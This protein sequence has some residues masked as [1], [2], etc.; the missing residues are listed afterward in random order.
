MKR[1][2]G[3]RLFVLLLLLAVATI[4]GAQQHKS[5]PARA[6][7]VSGSVFLITKGGD[8]KPARMADVYLLYLYPSVKQANAHP[9][10]WNSAVGLIFGENYIKAPL[11]IDCLKK[12]QVY[13]DALSQTLKWASA[14]HKDWQIL[15]TEADENGAFKIAVPR[16]GKYIILAS[17][18]AG[19]N[20]AFWWD[21]DGVVVNP[22]ATT[23]VKLSSPAKS[24][25]TD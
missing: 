15:T 18:H 10:E 16:P 5:Q 9:E 17:G 24:C 6:G 8:L 25:L 4:A 3:M 11:E 2:A 14:N 22:G 21:D 12:M 19:F 7:V 20:D 23:T 1:E 13:Y